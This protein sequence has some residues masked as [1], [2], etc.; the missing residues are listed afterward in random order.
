MET[1]PTNPVGDDQTH[2]IDPDTLQ[3]PDPSWSDFWGGL[4]DKM[5]TPLPRTT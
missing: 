4:W 2:S 3:P 5:T 1:D